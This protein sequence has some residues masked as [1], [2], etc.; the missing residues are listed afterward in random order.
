MKKFFHDDEKDLVAF[1]R[2]HRPLPPIQNP[3]L[4]NQVMELISQTSQRNSSENYFKLITILSSTIAVSLA[5]TWNGSRWGQQ[6]PQIA[7][8]Q[9]MVETFLI[10]S[11]ENTINDSTVF[12]SSEQEVNWFFSNIEES[13]Q[14]LSHSQ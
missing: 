10:N 13:P 12:F 1:I 4:E 6:K 14:V 5:V 11:W 8:E 9:N 2:Q 7:T 3:H